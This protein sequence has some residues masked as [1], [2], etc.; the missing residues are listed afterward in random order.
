MKVSYDIRR[1]EFY[2]LQRSCLN[3]WIHFITEQ[4]VILLLE[5]IEQLDDKPLLQFLSNELT[6]P[7]INDTWNNSH[8]DL[9]STLATLRGKYH[10]NI[11]FTLKVAKIG[12]THIL[13][14]S[15]FKLLVFIFEILNGIC[16]VGTMASG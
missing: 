10:N 6:W 1:N 9:E 5:T 8:F 11:L 2:L 15:F 3:F 7:V 13:Q 4:S 16:K 14:V 12:G